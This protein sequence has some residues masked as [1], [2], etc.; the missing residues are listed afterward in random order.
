MALM[1]NEKMRVTSKGQVTIPL[2]IR[3]KLG[4][5]PSSEVEFVISNENQV[6]LRKKNTQQER[7][8]QLVEKLRG[9][10]T[11]SMTTEQIMDLTRRETGQ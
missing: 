6:M 7:G 5:M 3:N 4:I 9:K 10:S 2:E 1:G 11:V 8:R